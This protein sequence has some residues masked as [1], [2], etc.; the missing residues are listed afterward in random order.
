MFTPAI[1]ATFRLL[2]SFFDSGWLE[3]CLLK[4]YGQRSGPIHENQTVGWQSVSMLDL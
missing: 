3:A 4:Q 1:R 2:D